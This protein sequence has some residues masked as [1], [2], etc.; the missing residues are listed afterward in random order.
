[1]TI[2][3][4]L[5]GTMLAGAACGAH[6]S[7]ITFNATPGQTSL[8]AVTATVDFNAGLLPVGFATY[9]NL[10]ALIPHPGNAGYAA[11]PPLDP[12]GF[13]SVGTTHGQPASS[14]V[15]FAGPGVSY[16]GFYMGSPDSYNVVTFYSGATTLL[17]LNG[18]QMANAAGYPADGNQN[19][20]FYMN[21]FS[22][23]AITKVTFSANQDAFETDNH[24]YIAA[25]PE[26]SAYALMLA[27]LGLIG[28]L[29]RRRAR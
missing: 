23:T 18:T 1:M 15:S 14:S 9:D 29:R 26:P 25:V 8:Q 20:G 2:A 17:T 12:T 28:V 7:T 22:G 13:F 5:L 6:A 3:K 10:N 11:Q 24:A 4:F 19:V 21:I 27:G 16:F